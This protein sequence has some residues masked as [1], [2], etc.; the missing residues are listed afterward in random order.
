MSKAHLDALAFVPGLEET[1]CP[2]E[3]SRH[4]AGIFVNITGHLS[5]GHIRGRACYCAEKYAEAVEAFSRITRPDYTHH[6]FLA[7]TF[8]RMDNAV[9]AAAHAAEVLKREP[10]FSA[11]VYLPTQHSKREVDR[12]RHE[13]GLLSAGLPI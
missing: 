1:L 13:A 5:D 9:A 8:A 12:R 2:H 7:A 6:A 10:K 4:V 3:P 11:T